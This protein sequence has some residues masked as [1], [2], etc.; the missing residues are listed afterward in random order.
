MM[1][2]MLAAQILGQSAHLVRTFLCK[3]MAWPVRGPPS[4]LELWK[5]HQRSSKLH[6]HPRQNLVVPQMCLRC[7][8]TST[9]GWPEQWQ[10]VSRRLLAKEMPLHLASW[11]RWVY[12]PGEPSRVS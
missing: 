3:P 4:H 11:A 9:Q 1:R 7:C 6:A 8:R 12:L 5:H 10:D 2:S